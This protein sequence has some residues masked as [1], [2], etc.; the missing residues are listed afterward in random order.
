SSPGYL[1]RTLGTLG[2]WFNS[3]PLLPYES[4]IRFGNTTLDS[5]FSPLT[6]T[7]SRI[8]NA[9]VYGLGLLA[10]LPALAVG[11]LI[12]EDLDTANRELTAFMQP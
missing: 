9:G 8:Y 11:V 10:N 3:A 2:E 7:V 1:D 6:E 5:V 12:D 4:R